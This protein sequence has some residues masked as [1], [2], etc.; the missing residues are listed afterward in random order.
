MSD[1]I[2]RVVYVSYSL[3]LPERIETLHTSSASHQF[4][5][6]DTSNMTQYYTHLAASVNEARARV[7]AELTA[8]KEAVGDAEQEKTDK[9]KAAESDEDD[10]EEEE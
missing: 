8:I 10:V 7:G 5:V 2:D 9:P 3:H 6:A 4:R 1:S